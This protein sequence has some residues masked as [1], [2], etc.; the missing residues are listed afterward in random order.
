[1]ESGVD[2]EHFTYGDLGCGQGFNVNLVAAAHPGGEFHA[3]DFNP[4]H[5]AGARRLARQA[6]A[7]NIHFYDDSFEDFG[8]RTD[9]P[10]FDII[11]LHGI[12]SRVSAENRRLIVDFIRSFTTKQLPGL[13]QL[14]VA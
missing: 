12:F 8:R 2:L 5:I 6:G 4:V 9:L 11:V 3:T 10:D 1:M 14:G 7:T 13:Q